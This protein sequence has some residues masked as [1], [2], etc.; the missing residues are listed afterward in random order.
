MFISLHA[1][2]PSLA[3]SP[4]GRV[5]LA[6]YLT[7]GWG[8]GWVGGPGIKEGS[9]SWTTVG[10]CPSAHR[11]AEHS[12]PPPEPGGPA[13]HAFRILQGGQVSR[14]G[15][16]GR[17]EGLT[18]EVDNRVGGM[19]GQG[20]LAALQAQ[21]HKLG[22]LRGTERRRPQ[23]QG[24]TVGTTD[25]WGD[26]AGGWAA[27]CR[28]CCSQTVHPEGVFSGRVS[29]DH[30]WVIEH[31]QSVQGQGVNLEFVQWE[32]VVRVEADVTDPSQRAGQFFREA[33]R[34]LSC[35]CVWGVGYRQ[36][37]QLDLGSLH[38]CS[39]SQCSGHTRGAHLSSLSPKGHLQ[40]LGSFL[41]VTTGGNATGIGWV[42]ARDAAQHPIVD[43][44]VL[45]WMLG[46]Q[47]Q[48]A[49]G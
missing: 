43:R 40:C 49:L 17:R 32:L 38:P 8:H 27:V 14:E 46:C 39:P 4:F 1:R 47:G 44:M 34:G 48:E 13:Q 37:A 30:V 22:R 15:P 42:E 31:V 19:G 2:P 45:T 24:D 36:K 16:R 26:G 9:E 25:R 28:A 41:V 3:P 6:H 10:R 12:A 23:A 33:R 29:Q 20:R 18:R 7:M 5:G 11:V 21:N 35:H